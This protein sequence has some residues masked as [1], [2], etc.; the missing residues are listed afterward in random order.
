MKSRP[1][2][3]D[4]GEL[5]LYMAYQPV[6][7][8][9][10]FH[11]EIIAYESLL[12][13]SPNESGHT[14]LS[15]ISEAE[16]SGSMPSLDARIARMVCNDVVLNPQMNVW[17]NI[18]QMTMSSLRSIQAIAGLIADYG[19]ANRV[20]VE[21]TETVNGQ[22][23]LIIES[24]RHL[25]NTGISVLLDDVDDGFSKPSLLSSELVSG[26]KLS[27]QSTER[28]AAD[29]E[30]KDKIIKFI[31]WCKTC[32]KSV[33]IEGIETERELALALELGA[34]YCQGYFLCPPQPLAAIPELGT[35]TDF[36]PS[37][38]QEQEYTWRTTN[39]D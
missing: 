36:Y 10:K 27:R 33:V 3:T 25:K 13:V 7:S 15:V 5:P 1:P 17:L 12:R 32:S 20:T 4:S 38:P 14:T 26:C 31:R 28:M 6:V 24:L 35:R 16:S 34:D 18:S 39:P 37:I 9:N 11:A 8:I 19:I 23:G 30:Y 21:M 2:V 22:L 29:S